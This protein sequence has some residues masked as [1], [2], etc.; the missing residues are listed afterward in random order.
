MIARALDGGAQAGKGPECARGA[1]V[2][3][4]AGARRPNDGRRRRARRAADLDFSRR[5]LIGE[6]SVPD[7]VAFQILDAEPSTLNALITRQANFVRC[8]AFILDLY[9]A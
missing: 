9:P 8:F 3:R 2:V 5:R 1:R 6:R 4:L 7:T